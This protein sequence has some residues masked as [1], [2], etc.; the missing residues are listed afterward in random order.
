MKEVTA[1]CRPAVA[2]DDYEQDFHVWAVK[3]AALLRQGR[4]AEIDVEH[5]AEELDDMGRS[6]RNEIEN[7]LINLLFHLL[8]WK[9]QPDRR[10]GSWRGSI[11]EARRRIALRIRRMPSLKNWPAACL[12]D[13]YEIARSKD[14]ENDALDPE[15]F[16]PTCLWT[17]MQVLD[18]G[19]LP[20]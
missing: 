17:V 14:P 8:K 16:P 11:R 20:E 13:A 7:Y 19:F 1:D 10:S 12:E 18:D 5:I 4:W 15:S 3:N 2:A 9:Y 6:E